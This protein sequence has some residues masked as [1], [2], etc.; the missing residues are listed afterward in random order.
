MRSSRAISL[1][2]VIAYLWVLVSSLGHYQGH[3]PMGAQHV[4]HARTETV[5]AGTTPEPTDCAICK[6]LSHFSGTVLVQPG[7][8]HHLAGQL[9]APP[10][11]E[12]A[13]PPGSTPSFTIRG[14]PA[15]V[16]HALFIG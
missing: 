4:V 9:S 13:S 2:T 12:V 8:S 11:P 3:F 16:P 15:T 10:S 7:A 14:P 1:L 6:L 5:Q